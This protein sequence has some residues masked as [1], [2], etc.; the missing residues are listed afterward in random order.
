MS[1]RNNRTV[2]KAKLELSCYSLM[3]H[4]QPRAVSPFE[5]YRLKHRL[6]PD[7]HCKICENMSEV[8]DIKEA[9]KIAQSDGGLSPLHHDGWKYRSV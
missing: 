5:S 4:Y 1:A 8:T 6:L 3:Q 7:K 2:N 9:E